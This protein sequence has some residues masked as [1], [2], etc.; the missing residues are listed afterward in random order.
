VEK[1]LFRMKILTMGSG[2]FTSEPRNKMYGGGVTTFPVKIDTAPPAQFLVELEPKDKVTVKTRTSAIFRTT[3]ALSGLDRYEVSIINVSGPGQTQGSTFFVETESPYR[4]SENSQGVYNIIVRAYDQAENF[5]ESSITLEVREP[6]FAL[7]LTQ[8]LDLGFR[9]VRWAL[10]IVPSFGVALLIGFLLFR[11]FRRHRRV[12]HQT[13]KGV[14]NLRK[15]LKAELD[16]IQGEVAGKAIASDRFAEQLRK[17]K[18]ISK[19]SSRDQEKKRGRGLFGGGAKM[20]MLCFFV[21][22]LSQLF[23][24]TPFPFVRAENGDTNAPRVRI[25]THQVE[26]ASNQLLYLTGVASP[27]SLVTITI[28]GEYQGPIVAR[29]TANEK[30]EWELLHDLYLQ[31][32]FYRVWAQA[33][34]PSGVESDTTEPIMFRVTS[35]LAAQEGAVLSSEV[36]LGFV[37]VFFVILDMVLVGYVF[38]SWHQTAR[39]RKRLKQ[40]VNEVRE[41]LQLGFTLI[42]RDIK[43]DLMLLEK[44]LKRNKAALA[45]ERSARESLLKSIAHIERSI[46]K[47][48]SDIHRFL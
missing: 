29:I 8:G 40:E 43:E 11:F 10:V 48:V 16:T 42:K 35:R 44:D 38:Y 2:I 25:L 15:R 14:D 33:K 20:L 17:L 34:S 39:H 1:P 45:K 4:F 9:V 30:G 13:E 46:K 23:P 37:A 6:A 3:D 47:E 41:A 18:E 5:Q 27:N 19:A 36:I 32:G 12:R 24:F 31:P 7:F 21:L 22:A 26:I 28:S